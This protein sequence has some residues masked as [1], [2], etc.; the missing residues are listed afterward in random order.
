MHFTGEPRSGAPAFYRFSGSSTTTDQSPEAST[1]YRSST[2]P[3]D[4]PCRSR[5]TGQD[6]VSWGRYSR[7]PMGGP[8]LRHRGRRAGRRHQQRRAG[9]SD[10]GPQPPLVYERV[11]IE[12]P[13]ACHDR[14]PTQAAGQSSGGPSEPSE[15]G[16][17]QC[18]D[19]TEQPRWSSNRG[20]SHSE[21]NRTSA[22]TPSESA[23]DAGDNIPVRVE[24]RP[25]PWPCG[26]R[27]PR[28]TEYGGSAR[29]LVRPIRLNETQTLQISAPAAASTA[30]P[31]CPPSQRSGGAGDPANRTAVDGG[32]T[33]ARPDNVQLRDPATRV[34]ATNNIVLELLNI[35]SLLPKMPD[36]RSEL[37][38]RDADILCFTETNLRNGTPDRLLSI[39]GY[40]V[41][42]RDREVGRKKSGGGVA[43][44][45]RETLQ[46]TRADASLPTCSRSHAETLWISIKLDKRRSA[47]IGLIYRPPS[48]TS[49]QTNSD[50]DHIEEQLQSIIA[51]N[52]SK[53]I[54]L[55][56]DL[57]A[58]SHTNPAAHLRLLE[59]QKYRLRNLVKVPTFYRGETRSILDVVLVSAELCD[60]P[61]PPKCSVE[62][63]HYA[64]H[65]HRVTITT[66]M[67]RTKVKPSY[68]TGR[69]WRGMDREAL[70]TDV[71]NVNWRAVVRR[72]DTCEQQ[73]NYFTGEMNRLLDIHAPN[74][75]YRVHNP[76]PPPVSE[77]TLDLMRQ[78]REASRTRNESYY[79][80][81]A[82]VK[83]AIRRDTR[84]SITERVNSTPASALYHQLQPVIAPKRGPTPTQPENLT[85]DQRN[86]YFTTIGIETRDAV[87]ENFEQS[88]RRN[89]AVRLPRVNTGALNIIPVN[90][91]QLKLTLFSMSN[92]DSKIEGDVPVHILKLCFCHIGK[93]LLQ[94]INTSIVTETV[95]SSWK[96][97]TV[98]PIYKK[99]DPS[100]A[101]N[102]R[103]VTIVP[104]ICK[105]VEKL[106]HKQIT[107]YL[108]HN[109][110][111]S[112]DQHGFMENHSTCTA[113]ISITDEILR[114]M[115]KS[116]V[117][118]LTLIDLSRCFDVVDHNMLITKLQ[119]LQISTGW[120]QSYLEGHTQRVRI[121][122][123]LSESR[124]IT[125]GIFQGT[126]LGPLFYNIAS[127][128]I[129][130]FIPPHV[131][132]F[133][134]S[135]V[136]YADDAQLA[137]TGP[138]D[139]LSEIQQSLE[140]VLD[141]AGSCRG[142]V[143]RK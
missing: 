54:I 13:P 122:Q 108:T 138:R 47:I 24:R 52:P 134:I 113:L 57:N 18:T 14:E 38:Q 29:C 116:E 107:S 135:F 7:P 6:W 141:V 123:T 19:V 90:L 118:L 130:C 93:V 75:T 72:G 115:D 53:R 25:E 136:R 100:K 2:G 91:E 133:R 129:A 23:G 28:L 78:R 62:P 140:S 120:I 83:R 5:A 132:G 79:R 48:T 50:F 128:D 16:Q 67:P 45:A 105:I 34:A 12:L 11:L 46:V 142:V 30:P 110:L 139:K 27:T 35:Q 49:T 56:G 112:H 33:T 76:S 102:F 143:L 74:R 137:I 131:N 59:L 87:R 55:A 98:I 106:V 4:K 117:T 43:V 109:H 42:R 1:V 71:Q 99:S 69:N 114:G 31:L 85:P 82:Q 88:G 37:Q 101:S 20:N 61:N 63:C 70:V 97:A 66:A 80:L 84:E 51:A 119:Q 124:D 65:H 8:R 64:S 81:N 68:R 21:E 32:A 39:P 36:V 125:V 3:R 10:P 111:F 94:I 22:P 77:D 15:R 103:P 44:F 40:N 127:N 86:R 95:P 58:D 92:K 121:G 26:A 104:A 9:P 96:C 126:C 60:G 17:L 41:F 73:W 89:L